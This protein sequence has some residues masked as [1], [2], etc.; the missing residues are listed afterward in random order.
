MT[1]SCPHCIA[2][3]P[4]FPRSGRLH[5]VKTEALSPACQAEYDMEKFILSCASIS[6]KFSC[7]YM[8]LG[9]YL[10]IATGSGIFPV[11][12]HFTVPANELADRMAD[13]NEAHLERVA[14]STLTTHRL[15]PQLP[16]I[17]ISGITL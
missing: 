4:R 17:D 8:G 13:A 3:Y 7:T 14:R 2:G 12:D 1:T 9:R 6:L 15:E 11:T 16:F 10:V 5:H